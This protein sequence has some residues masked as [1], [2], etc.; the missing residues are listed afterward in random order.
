MNENTQHE[1]QGKFLLQRSP[2]SFVLDLQLK[3]SEYES[4]ATD[5]RYQTSPGDVC[6]WRR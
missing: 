3:N 4:K 5:P 1:S 6:T 2:S